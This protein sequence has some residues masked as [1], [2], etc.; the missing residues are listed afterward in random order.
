M[1]ERGG[2]RITEFL[3]NLDGV[4]VFFLGCIQIVLLLKRLTQT[5]VGHPD[6]P[7]L[8]PHLVEGETAHRIVT[9]DSQFSRSFI[10]LTDLHIALSKALAVMSHVLEQF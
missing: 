9:S 2:N 1:A 3:F 8:I 10:T 6:Q 7:L 5:L 4:P